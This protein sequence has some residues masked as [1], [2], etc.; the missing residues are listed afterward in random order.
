MPTVKVY[1]DHGKLMREGNA[2]S[3]EVKK[4][5][6]IIR[7][8]LMGVIAMMI[9]QSLT[10]VWWASGIST[11]V[12][13][14]AEEMKE[15]KVAMAAGTADRYR[16]SDAAKDREVINDRI[17]GVEQRVQ[18][19]F[20]YGSPYLDKRLSVVEYKLGLPEKRVADKQ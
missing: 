19:L 9:I 20:D 10:A 5:G 2:R 17:A 3:E 16:G 18:K 4:S 6:F 12:K 14:M 8:E 11:N 13:F 15:L 1:D 7:Y